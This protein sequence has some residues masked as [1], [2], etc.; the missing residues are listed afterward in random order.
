MSVRTRSN[1]KST[2]TSV[3]TTNGSGAITGSIL[4]SLLQDFADSMLMPEDDVLKIVANW[5]A[6]V[7]LF[8]DSPAYTI[9]KGDIFLIT[10]AGTLGGATV[11]PGAEIRALA[12][13]PG[14]TFASW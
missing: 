11:E 8:P 12:D 14:Q 13:A 5:N 10:V 3:I 4:N 6:S 7:N 1:L 2:I 9:V